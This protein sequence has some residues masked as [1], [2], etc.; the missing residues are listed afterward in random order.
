VIDLDHVAIATTD[1][2]AALA[3]VV[4]ELGGTV[5]AGGDG[6]GFRWVQV[7]LDGGE[8]DREGDGMTVELLTVWEPGQNDFLE[9]FVARHGPGQHHLT[10]K[11]KDL[12][13]T[14]RRV[15]Q[16]GFRPVG[17]NLDDP[18]WKEAFLQPREAHGT[19]VQ[20]AEVHPDHPG[21][22]ELVAAAD[23]G[24]T[25][26][27]PMWWPA[28][29]ARATSRAT[30]DRVVMSTP[31]LPAALPFFAGILEGDVVEESATAV[32]LA[33]PGSGRIRLELDVDARPGFLRLEGRSPDGARTIDLSGA[34]L[35]LAPR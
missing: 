22:A 33:W 28:P 26:G 14:L 6:Y 3:T 10:F 12:A 8:G 31:S 1:I 15:G 34:P 18:W 9:R 7:R 24:A 21:T 29:P 25:I 2:A 5:F 13:D 11:V 20:L 17:V 23:A 16:A 32:E 35:R 4:G 27:E 19:V 30:L